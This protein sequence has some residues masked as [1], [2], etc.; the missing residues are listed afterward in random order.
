MYGEGV[1]LASEDGGTGGDNE[2]QHP[3]AECTNL[4]YVICGY[5]A[6]VGTSAVA[7]WWWLIV[8]PFIA[9]FS[10][11]IHSA[12]INRLFS[13]F[14]SFMFLWVVTAAIAVI[15]RL[16]LSSYFKLL[17][18]GYAYAASCTSSPLPS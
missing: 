5:L 18:I 8:V 9:I 17:L 1:G 16:C 10:G 13:L 14:G 11:E 15:V 6:A 4:P 12:D 7:F 2:T 3:P